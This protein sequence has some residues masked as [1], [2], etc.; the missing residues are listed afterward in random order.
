MLTCNS[1]CRT[2]FLEQGDTCIQASDWG[3]ADKLYLLS[4]STAAPA[5]I[6]VPALY[7]PKGSVCAAE[8]A[9]QS[10]AVALLLWDVM[11]SRAPFVSYHSQVSVCTVEVR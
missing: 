4:L 2:R 9:L 8:Y 7:W 5:A 10:T 11:L 3:L 6:L 1:V